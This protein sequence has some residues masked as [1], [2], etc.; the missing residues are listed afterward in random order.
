MDQRDKRCTLSAGRAISQKSKDFS[1]VHFIP[2]CRVPIRHLRSASPYRSQ[3]R[4]EDRRQLQVCFG[5][6]YASNISKSEGE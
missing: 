3:G 6:L 5:M 4:A 1:L 2:V